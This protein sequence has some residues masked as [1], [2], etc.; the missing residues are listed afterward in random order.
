MT[1]TCWFVIGWLTWLTH[2]PLS[3]V[4]AS[5]NVIIVL[6]QESSPYA[7]MVK[8]FRTS[9]TD[10]GAQVD[11]EVHNLKGRSEHAS[12]VL[13]RF[14]NEPPAMFLTAGSLATQGQ[15]L[16]PRLLLDQHDGA[17]VSLHAKLNHQSWRNRLS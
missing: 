16:T 6:S 3:A 7:D 12:E 14:K 4:A 13:G 10:A 15:V 1:I 2:Q 17:G 5:P 11:I 9:L 8:V